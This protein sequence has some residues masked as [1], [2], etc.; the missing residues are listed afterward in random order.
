MKKAGINRFIIP[1]LILALF[2]VNIMHLKALDNSVIVLP[3]IQ[4]ARKE[5]CEESS[6]LP[7]SLTIIGEEAFEGTA[8]TAVTVNE[9]LLWIGDR[10][11]SNTHDLTDIYIPESTV[12]IGS[13][14]LPAGALIHGLKGSYAQQWAD[15]NGSGFVVDDIWGVP[16]VTNGFHTNL[17]LFLVFILIPADDSCY[18]SLSRRI[19]LFIRSMRPQD[20]PE[21]H[22]IQYRFP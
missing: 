17:L 14:A 19:R 8:L 16:T 18:K 20:R 3:E 1:I 22:P 10:A 9:G 6:I 21:M 11:F 2:G 7:K 5:T 13:E 15:E 12:F 4:I